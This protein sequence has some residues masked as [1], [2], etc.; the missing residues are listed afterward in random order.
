MVRYMSNV[1]YTYVYWQR[2]CM[3]FHFIDLSFYRMG[4]SMWMWLESVGW[5]V[6]DDW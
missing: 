4:A 6:S 1:Y 2:Y 5:D 3:N